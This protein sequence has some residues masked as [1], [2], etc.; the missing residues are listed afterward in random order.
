MLKVRL[1][2]PGKSVKRRNHFKIVVIEAKKP[3][4]SRF[5]KQLGYYDPSKKLLKIDLEAYQNWLGKGAQPTK[6]VASLAKRYKK[7]LQKE[8]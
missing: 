2:K 8:Q 3:R 7:T 1:M 4:D 5:I 6:T